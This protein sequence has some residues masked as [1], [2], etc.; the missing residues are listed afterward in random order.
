MNA[1]A[2]VLTTGGNSDK[3]GPTS[4]NSSQHSRKKPFKGRNALKELIEE[5]AQEVDNE[6]NKSKAS[7]RKS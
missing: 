2:K 1:Y 5:E 4:P 3:D 7:R 6:L